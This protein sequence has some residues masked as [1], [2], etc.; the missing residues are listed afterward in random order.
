[1]I[2]LIGFFALGLGW[3]MLVKGY[4]SSSAGDTVKQ[5]KSDMLQTGD[6]RWYKRFRPEAKAESSGSSG[7]GETKEGKKGKDKK[8]KKGKL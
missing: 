2:V 3:P 1:M 8:P 4:G 6:G 5:R 7:G